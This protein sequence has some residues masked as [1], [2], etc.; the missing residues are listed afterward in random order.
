MNTLFNDED[1]KRSFAYLVVSLG[2]FGIKALLT[3]R[4][5]HQLPEPEE[6]EVR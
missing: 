4:N 2:I 6:R 5:N 1:V 3:M